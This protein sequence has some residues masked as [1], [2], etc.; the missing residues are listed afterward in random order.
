MFSLFRL[1][2]LLLIAFVMGVAYERGQQQVLCEQSGG[3]WVRA[4]YCVE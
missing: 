4:G 3:Q 2:I 1:P